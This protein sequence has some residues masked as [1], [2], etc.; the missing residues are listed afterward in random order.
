MRSSLRNIDIPFVEHIVA[1]MF[2]LW[3]PSLGCHHHP[4]ER[5]G[6]TPLVQLPQDSSSYKPDFG[7]NIINETYINIS[8]YALHLT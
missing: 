5:N 4:M 8:Y 2:S 6:K 1:N 7:Q 3:V